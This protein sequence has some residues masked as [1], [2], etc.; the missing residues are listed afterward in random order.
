MNR[1]ASSTDYALTADEVTVRLSRNSAPTLDCVSLQ[2]PSNDRRTVVG[3]VGPNGCGKTTL[4]KTLLGAIPVESGEVCVRG[5]LA[6][7]KKRKEIAQEVSLVAQTTRNDT[8]LRVREIVMLGRLP[9][10]G[11]GGPGSAKDRQIVAEAL[12]MV[13][14]GE[15]AERYMNTLSGGERQRVLIAQA[16]AQQ[17]GVILLDEPTNHLDIRYQHEVLGLLRELPVS[18]LVVLH[19]LNLAAHYCDV[20]HV[21]EAGRIV[22][23][24]APAE[25]LQPSILEPIYGVDIELVEVKGQLHLLFGQAPATTAR[26]QSTR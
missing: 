5:E 24:G 10:A 1:T 4:L 26:A 13:G 25:V 11:L 23:S 15:L 6:S 7:R 3:L 2:V 8:S 14:A 18:A 22:A 9:H 21:M 16:L 19:D 20:I 12:R 17:T